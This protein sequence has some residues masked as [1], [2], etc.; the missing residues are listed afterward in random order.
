[1]E[2]WYADFPPR[3]IF[4]LS[5]FLC[6]FVS[7][8]CVEWRCV[9]MTGGC[10][11]LLAANQVLRA[12]SLSPHPQVIM[13]NNGVSS[14][15]GVNISYHCVAG[16]GVRGQSDLRRGGREGKEGKGTES[17]REE[18][19]DE[20]WVGV[21]KG[22]VQNG[23][24]CTSHPNK[25]TSSPFSLTKPNQ[26]YPSRAILTYLSHPSPSRSNATQRNEKQPN[27]TQHNATKP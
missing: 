15:Q 2:Q 5:L 7:C 23:L 8:S 10:Y 26:K 11:H 18:G 13:H 19:V 3:T 9:C 22:S 27:P 16:S 14:W 1:M 24:Y 21:R 6:V 4:S 17:W 25:I 20:E 12:S